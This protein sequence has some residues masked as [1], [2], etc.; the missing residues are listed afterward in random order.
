MRLALAFIVA[1]LS[2]PALAQDPV[3]DPV[4]QRAVDGVIRPGI[5][6]FWREASGLAS[7]MELLCSTPSAA[8]LDMAESQFREAALAYGRI[9]L[10]RLGPL[11]EDNRAE[12][13]LFWPDRKGIALRQVQAILAE[14]DETATDPVTLRGKSVAVQGLGAL[15]YVLFGTGADALAG[16]EGDF[17]CRFGSAVA[18]SIVTVAQDLSSS[19]YQPNGVA[20]RLM[21]PEAGNADYRTP[22]E[23]TEA[24]VGLMANGFE[25]VRD[26]RI[27][28]FIA[29][30]GGKANPKLALFWRSGLTVPML[31]ANVDALRDLFVVSGVGQSTPPESVGLAG[32]IEFE[33]A[34]ADR[35]LKLITLPLEEAVID[36]RQAQA[37]AYLAIVTG[38]LQSLIGEQ[39]SA[40]L[41]LS[42]GFSS[43]DGD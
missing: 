23:A 42:V 19:W 40:A 33:F 8:A 14:K 18:Q 7:S 36:P 17:R 21:L 4:M 16:T 1:L 12:R 22:L 39:L 13:L 43:L 26:T 9:E 30:D 11:M 35:A 37:L 20:R 2:L 5:V 6:G 27:N 24:L 34:N 41:A 25:A 29:K 10:L 3:P 38:S 28:P 31:A 32:S 15:E